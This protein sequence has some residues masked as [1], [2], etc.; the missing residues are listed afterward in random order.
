MNARVRFVL[1]ALAAALPLV[2]QTSPLVAQTPLAPPSTGILVSYQYWPVQ[3]VQCVGSE[4]PYSMIELD[5]DAGGKQPLYNVILTDRAGKR[6]TYANT[7]GLVRAATAQGMEAHKA[8]IA[9][10]PAEAQA[11]GAASTLRMTLADGRPLQWRF[12]QGSDV[13]EQGAGLTP[14][15]NVAI[16]VLLYREQQRSRVRARCCRSAM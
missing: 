4:L 10:E 15:P 13:S 12:V 7:E 11:V 2:A 1:I 3:Y 16:P 9:F 8:A 14:L 5:V 6:I